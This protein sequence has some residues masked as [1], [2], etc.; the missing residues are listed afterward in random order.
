MRTL[1]LLTLAWC[2]VLG[3]ALYSIASAV[4]E[5]RQQHIRVMTGD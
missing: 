1:I 4:V 3:I 2:I 5:S